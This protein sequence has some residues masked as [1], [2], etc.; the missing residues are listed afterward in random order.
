MIWVDLGQKNVDFEHA[1]GETPDI[2]CSLAN[3][4]FEYQI[5]SN[6][7]VQQLQLSEDFFS[8]NCH[9]QPFTSE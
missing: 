1:L 3:L 9:L 4:K 5:D 6:S 7:Q 2:A 8:L